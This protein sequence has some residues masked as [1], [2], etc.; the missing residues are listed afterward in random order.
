MEPVFEIGAAPATEDKTT[1]NVATTSKPTE[2]LI[3]R[4]IMS[5]SC[6]WDTSQ[7]VFT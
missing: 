2:L 1:P 4:L 5:F 6:S 3:K 7:F